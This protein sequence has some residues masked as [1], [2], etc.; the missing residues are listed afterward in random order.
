MKHA[1]PW[2]GILMVS[3]TATAVLGLVGVAAGQPGAK[4]EG[5][6]DGAVTEQM[7]VK[8]KTLYSFPE[9]RPLEKAAPA[10]SSTP[11]QAAGEY[12]IGPG[13]TLDFQ[14]LDDT[15]MNRELKVRYDGYISLPQIDE[16]KVAGMTRAEVLEGLNR[17]Y[18]GVYRKPHISL[19]V[20]D[21]G[22][23]TFSM[24]GDVEKPGEYPYTRPISVLEALNV[25]G[26][27]RINTTSGNSY[28][29][30]QGQLSK[31]FVIRHQDGKREVHEYDLSGIRRDGESPSDAPV[32]PGDV[33]YLPEGMNL[34]YVMGEAVTPGVFPLVEGMSLLELLARAGGANEKTGRM[35]GVMLLRQVDA[36]NT[37][38]M[39]IDLRKCLDTG[40][41][42]KLQ[43]GDILYVPRGKLVRLYDNLMRFT[44][45]A[46]TV[47]PLLNLYTQG[48]DTYF[49][50]D[51]YNVLLHPKAGTSTGISVPTSTT[52]TAAKTQQ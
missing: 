15:A 45:L 2:T 5:V 43:A 27:P 36:E 51:L 19:T 22:S 8:T 35:R 3:L 1:K 48:Y 39:L 17:A 20:K 33:V 34:V 28:I 11:A 9:R 32:L 47:S 6:R 14:L 10:E 16:M 29:G 50:K 12:R 18:L 46:E 41:S 40:Q 38:A 23:K 7:I 13:D 25:A 4:G 31:A 30:A 42:P 37:E 21:A 52:T 24:L 49:K 44:R 26:G